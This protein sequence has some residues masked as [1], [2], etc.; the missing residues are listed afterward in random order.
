MPRIPFVDGF[1][2]QPLP[3]G[4]DCPQG[5]G[6]VAC[7]PLFDGVTA[8][9]LR[10]EVPGFWEIREKRDA[11][12]INFCANGRFECD[13][14]PRDHVTLTPGDMAVSTFDGTHGTRAE[15]RF[16]LG[17]YEGVSF[18]VDCPA[19][20]RWMAANVPALATD[21]SALKENLLGSRWCAAESAGP[22]CEHVFREFYE[23]LPYFS[24]DYL[25]LKALELFMLLQKIPRFGR[26]PDYCSPR[27]LELVRHLRD[28]L[29][30]DR[31]GRVSLP[32]LAREHGLSVSHLQKLFRQTYGAPIYHYVK[33]YRL[34]QAAV[35]L[36]KTR[37]RVTEIALDAGYDSA[38]KFTEAFKK[39]YG[40]TPSAFRAGAIPESDWNNSAVLE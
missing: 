39:R 8:M 20:T 19:A 6:A 12:E 2:G 34:E 36:A 30:S 7:Y 40:L 18:D 26:E 22:R 9:L 28:H 11:L 10:L 38:S 33:E 4:F 1:T 13:F 16:P 25:R 32:V 24:R 29:L 15:S 23:N 31:T 14:S 35:E 3:H 5:S 27:Q 37:R 21:F 17:Y